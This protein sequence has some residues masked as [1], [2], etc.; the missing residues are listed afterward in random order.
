MSPSV[1]HP[2]V[3]HPSVPHNEPGDVGPS[4]RRRRLAAGLTLDQLAEASGVSSAMI[5]EVERSVKNPTVRLA[6]QIARAL[7]CTLSELLDDGAT[8]PVQVVRAAERRTF[9]DEESGVVRHGLSPE[10]L[11]R[12]IELVLYEIPAHS[13]T[14]EMS[15][16]RP[17]ILEHVVVL[18]GALTL[19]SGS[20]RHRLVVGDGA[21]Y[22]PQTATEY[23]N[24]TVRSCRFLL[25]ADSTRAL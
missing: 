25:C 16:N 6:Y 21:T 3:P 2:S 10:L 5:S 13:S 7:K 1:P 12:G 22:G 9:R 20:E 17:G 23:R 18:Q 19:V 14:G 15:A 24:D 11:R 8:H 4:M